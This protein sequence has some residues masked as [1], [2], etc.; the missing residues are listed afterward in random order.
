MKG[1]LADWWTEEDADAVQGAR[2]ACWRSSSTRYEPLPGLHIN[3]QATLGENIADFG[4]VLLGL[5]AF[6]KTEQYKKG[7]TIGGLTPMQRYF[8]GYALGWQQQAGGA[9]P[10]PA[11][12]RRARAGEVARARAALEC[13][14]VLRGLRREAG[15]AD[16]AAGVGARGGLVAGHRHGT[17]LAITPRLAG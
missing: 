6:K 12:E 10:A 17:A 16:V 1:N 4:G 2:R 7:E 11:A 5:D 14:G 15:R 9:S 3:G 13:P 8:L